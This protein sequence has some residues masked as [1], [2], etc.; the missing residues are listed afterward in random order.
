MR[1]IEYVTG[2]SKKM[3][4]IHGLYHE[5]MEPRRLADHHRAS[6]DATAVMLTNRIAVF[7]PAI[8]RKRRI[9]E[10]RSLPV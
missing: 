1:V 10:K 4:E 7:G 2:S 5:K 3:Y 6:F 9:R 8:Y